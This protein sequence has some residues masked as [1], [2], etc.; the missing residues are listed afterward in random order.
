MRNTHRFEIRCTCIQYGRSVYRPECTKRL[1]I[2]KIRVT[3]ITCGL[4]APKRHGKKQDFLSIHLHPS[5]SAMR[6]Y[7]QQRFAQSTV[8]FQL[9]CTNVL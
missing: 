6:N 5:Y 4:E 9:V 7:Q 8:D 1:I 2:C 3:L